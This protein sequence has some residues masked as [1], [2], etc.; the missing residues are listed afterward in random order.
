MAELLPVWVSGIGGTPQDSVGCARDEMYGGRDCPG[1]FRPLKFQCSGVLCCSCYHACKWQKSAK[2]NQ[3]HRKS[4]K[5]NSQ[6]NHWQSTYNGFYWIKYCCIVLYGSTEVLNFW[7]YRNGTGTS[8]FEDF[9][10]KQ[11]YPSSVL[12]T[13]FCCLLCDPLFLKDELADMCARCER[14]IGTQG[15]GMDQAISLMAKKGT[16]SQ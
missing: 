7:Y 2:G 15:G 10:I 12:F 6:W 16:V 14:Y 5:I 13:V 9:F 1:E 8:T 3:Y 11:T 4:M